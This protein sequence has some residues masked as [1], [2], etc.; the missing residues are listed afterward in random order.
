MAHTKSQ[1]SS[2]NGR[3][4]AGQRL[5]VKRY[6]SQVV[7]AGEV[8]VRQNGTHFHPGKNVGRASNDTLYAL[9]GGIVTFEW[10]SKTPGRWG[11]GR[12]CVSVYPAKSAV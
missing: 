9:V 1:G 6:G 11:R 5:G 8:L 4:S 10:M 7:N 12:Q 2:T 3:D